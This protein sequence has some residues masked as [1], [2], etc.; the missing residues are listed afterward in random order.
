VTLVLV[1]REAAPLLFNLR[2]A[3]GLSLARAVH[4]FASGMTI[5]DEPAGATAIGTSNSAENPATT[6]VLHDRGPATCVHRG[7]SRG[8]VTTGS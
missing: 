3:D 5:Y 6:R 8:S 7:Q 1:S 4:T 2:L